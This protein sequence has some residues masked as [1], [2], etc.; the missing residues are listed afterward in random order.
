M[1]KGHNRGCGVQ[2]N[3][4]DPEII[5]RNC[6]CA[7]PAKYTNQLSVALGQVRPDFRNP[8]AG[9]IEKSRQLSEILLSATAKNKRCMQFPEHHGRYDY[10]ISF[11]EKMCDSRITAHEGSV[12]VRIEANLV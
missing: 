8:A 12:S 9:L 4:C 3:C 10:D 7:L 5:G 11:L 2:C 6:W 1:I